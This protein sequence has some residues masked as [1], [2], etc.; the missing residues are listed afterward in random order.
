MKKLITVSILTLTMNSAIAQI[1]EFQTTRLNS[2]AGAGVASILSTEA[3]ILNPAA[4]AY[5]EEGAISY[6]SYKA[7]L[8]KK[9]DAR[10]TIPDKFSK[11]N[12]SQALFISD[13]SG[14]VKGGVA[15]I[16]QAENRYDR[17]R[18]IF[19]AASPMGKTSALGFS[20]N[21]INDRL[22]SGTKNRH[23]VHHQMNVGLT[24]ILSEDLT[25]GLVIQDVTRTTPG[26][27][28]VLLGFQY[29]LTEKIVAIADTGAQYTKSYKKDNLWRAALQVNLFQDVFVRGGKFEDNVQDF[30]G[31]GWGIGWIGPRLGIEFAQKISDHFGKNTYIYKDER[32]VDSSLSAVIK[33]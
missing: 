9:N 3:A 22:P 1:R 14:K 24:E 11:Q 20:Y 29:K 12:L 32:I 21:Y 8:Q 27:E 26:E 33:F 31:Y 5:F 23:R 16:D 17:T 15:Y 18:A 28:R 13:Y 7:N 10:D 2:S 30:R 19:H 4:A 6:Q 25:M